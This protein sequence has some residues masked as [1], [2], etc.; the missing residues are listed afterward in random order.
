MTQCLFRVCVRDAQKS[1]ER[2]F[3][4]VRD[5]PTLNPDQRE[6]ASPFYLTLLPDPADSN[7]WESPAILAPRMRGHSFAPT[8]DTKALCARSMSH[9]D[10]WGTIMLRVGI[11]LRRDHPAVGTLA[12]LRSPCR[13]L[14]LA[15]ERRGA[16]HRSETIPCQY[17]SA[18]ALPSPALAGHLL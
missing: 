16:L 10:C 17:A 5:L 3:A 13:G 1:E 14:F 11:V 2:F 9:A 8:R 6:N 12:P 4:S 15:L 7:P 18:H